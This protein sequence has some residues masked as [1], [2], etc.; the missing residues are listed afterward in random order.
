MKIDDILVIGLGEIGQPLLEIIKGVYPNARGYDITEG[1]T[2]LPKKLDVLHICFPF[3]DKFV[4]TVGDYISS[5]NPH[6]TLIESTVP[7]GTTLEIS[8]GS[9]DCHIV[10]SPVRGRKADGFKFCYF[11]YTKFIGGVS[12][13]AALEAKEYYESLGFKTWVCKT[14]LESEFAKIM[15]LSYFGLLLGWN[16]EMRRIAETSELEFSDIAEFFRTNTK[17]SNQRFPRP[18]LDGRSIGGHCIKPAI[19]ML[20]EQFSSKFLDAILDSDSRRRKEKTYH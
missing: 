7:P 3:N 1:D 17:E 5:T 13:D 2:I 19:K 12:I 20:G 18:V 10:H 14:S 8:F 11:N 4:Q 9:K 6:L 16:Q 15:N